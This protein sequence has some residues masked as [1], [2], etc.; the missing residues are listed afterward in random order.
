MVEVTWARG[1][2]NT[3]SYKCMFMLYSVNPKYSSS[4]GSKNKYRLVTSTYGVYNL[5]EE[6][7]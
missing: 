1:D 5:V 7:E 6:T 2:I 4:I 3:C